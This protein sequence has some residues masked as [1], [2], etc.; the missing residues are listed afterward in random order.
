MFFL[1]GI[2]AF[3][4]GIGGDCYDGKTIHILAHMLIGGPIKSSIIAKDEG[5][6]T[7][8]FWNELELKS[9][10]HCDDLN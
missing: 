5:I 7:H 6:T 1:C 3:L 9:I 10:V 4:A 8:I 2:V